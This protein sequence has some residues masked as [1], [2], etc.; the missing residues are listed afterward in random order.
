MPEDVRG[1]IRFFAFFVAN[2]TLCQEVLRDVDDYRPALF[3]YG[4]ALEKVFAIYTNVLEYDDQG[5]PTNDDWAARRAAQWIRSYL[6]HNYS[7][8]PPF[9]DWEVTLH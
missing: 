9:E 7:V 1:A 5:R 6:D 2:G 4:S 3:E 8:D